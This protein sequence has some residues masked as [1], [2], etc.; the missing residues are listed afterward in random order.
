M[1]GSDRS[2][3]QAA[4]VSVPPSLSERSPVRDGAPKYQS[5]K[6]PWLR[7][8]APSRISQPTGRPFARYCADSSPV[9]PQA[10]MR[11]HSVRSCCPP[12]LSVHRSLVASEKLATA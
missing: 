10:T 5:E 1:T 12:S 7:L 9:L 6:L 4:V 8:R 3:V 2:I 11:C